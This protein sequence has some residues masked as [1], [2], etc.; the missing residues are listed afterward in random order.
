MTPVRQMT[1]PE[2]IYQDPTQADHYS[3]RFLQTDIEYIR[4][5][6]IPTWVSVEEE[7]PEAQGMYFAYI[8]DENGARDPVA[9][10]FG[11][12]EFLDFPQAGHKITHW[13][14][15]VPP[16]PTKEEDHARKDK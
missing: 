3:V 8:T 15:G 2:R 16:L 5:D 14:K 9:A 4:S 13:L 7:L 10:Y 11:G 12:K 1:A 6:L